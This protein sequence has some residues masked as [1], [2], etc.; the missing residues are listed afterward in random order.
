M[1][2]KGT[3]T[4]DGKRRNQYSSAYIK[5]K[6]WETTILSSGDTGIVIY[7]NVESIKISTYSNIWAY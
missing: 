6:R 4:D 7:A 5:F 3:D 2:T 1:E